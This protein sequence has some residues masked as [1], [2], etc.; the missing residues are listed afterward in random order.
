MDFDED[1]WPDLME[2]NDK[3]SVVLPN[4]LYRNNGNGTFTSVAAQ[5]GAQIG[6][7]GMSIDFTDA[8]NDGGVDYYCTDLPPDHL[9]QVWDP[10]LGSYFQAQAMFGVEGGD[11]GWAAHFLDYDNDGWQDLHVVQDQAP[12][13]L[14]HNPG[15]PVSAGVAWPDMAPALGIDF[16]YRQYTT[17]TADF[18]D[19]GQ[20][21][22]LHRFEQGP[23]WLAYP[24]GVLI[25]QN[26]TS[27]NNWLK[28][29]LEGTVSNRDALGTRIEVTTGTHRQRQWV[30]NGAGYI[31]GSDPRV[32]F[33]LGTATVVD[34]V[35]ITWPSGQVQ[36]LTNVAPNQIL[37]LQEP[38]LEIAGAVVA[39]GAPTTLQGAF[40]GDDGLLY[41][42]FLANSDVP[43]PLPDGTV[44]PLLP[45]ALT[46][47]TL[48]PGNV[49]LPN[50][51]GIVGPGGA[52]SSPLSMP[53]IPG[54][55][56]LTLYASAV[57]LDM[58]TFPWVRTVF[59]QANAFTIQ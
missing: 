6:I 56:G 1:G 29:D 31:S 43:L 3:G 34:Q 45:D 36:H 26:L 5:Y 48:T 24:D 42:M 25:T 23:A 20:V 7:H 59:P 44:L 14:F 12:N 18:D 11:L 4:D 47:Y 28:F 17:G 55:P 49:M 10:T 41:L 58:P 8:F 53:A 50:S 22:I 52:V 35:D 2:V 15:T 27:N 19:D 33:G 9:F 21:D 13:L 39:G 30:R 57:T 37:V 51:V 38:H 40:P 32:H 54:L 46:S 16:A